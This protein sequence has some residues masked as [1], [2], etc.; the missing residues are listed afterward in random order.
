MPNTFFYS[1][2]IDFFLNLIFSIFSK[3]QHNRLK[4]VQFSK[5]NYTNQQKNET[6]F[7]HFHYFQF[8]IYLYV[9]LSLK[10]YTYN[11]SILE[12]GLIL[13]MKYLIL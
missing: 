11:K 1:T 5:H 6:V 12:Y 7:G 10:I 13:L 4:N 8:I 2:Y 3:L 9:F